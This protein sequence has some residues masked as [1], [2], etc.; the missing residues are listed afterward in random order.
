MIRLRILSVA[1]FGILS[2]SALVFWTYEEDL[3]IKNHLKL[4]TEFYRSSMNSALHAINDLTDLVFYLK[5][6]EDPVLRDT[7]RRVNTTNMEELHWKIYRRYLEIYKNI[8][9]E[10]HV[11]Q[12]HFH[13]P[14]AISFVRMHR[15]EKFGDSLKGIRRSIELVNE[16]L[17]PVKCFEEGRVFNGFRNVY[18]IL[19][20][21]TLLGTVEISY[22]A[23]AVEEVMRMDR[24]I[25]AELWIRRDIVHNKVWQDERQN[26]AKLPFTPL[27]MLDK[28]THNL[29][30]LTK[31]EYS[32]FLQTMAQKPIPLNGEEQALYFKDKLTVFLPIKNCKGEFTAYMV[33]F[34]RD[35]S[36]YHLNR[37]FNT[38]IALTLLVNA[39]VSFLT[40]KLSVKYRLL[41]ESSLKDALTGVLNRRAFYEIAPKIINL[42]KRDNAPVSLIMCDI[43]NF[44]KINDTHGH[45]KG[46]TVLR[47]VAKT[48]EKNLRRGDLVARYGGEEFV[49][50]IRGDLES[51]KA[52]AEKLR[53]KIE[54][55]NTEGIKVTCSFGVSQMKDEEDLQELISRSDKALY[56]AKKLG[57]NRV[58]VV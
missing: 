5:I 45:Q 42:A 35:P 8:L 14:G 29:K 10:K 39:L 24:N 36:I 33:I 58:E 9:R 32:L 12:L 54:K 46:D 37:S 55:L 3:A 16:T 44:K 15:P 53:S 28:E 4:Q 49:T 21:N 40:Y 56:K 51:A 41:R 11:R 23:N 38:Y 1:L 20:G 43:D 47:S 18:P 2:I 6:E 22:D 50:L 7:L 19:E 26:Y 17:R 30:A 31:E 34:S 27:F 52:V 13:L 57:K 48:I 25:D